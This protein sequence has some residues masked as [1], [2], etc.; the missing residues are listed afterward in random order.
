MFYNHL[1]N[2]LVYDQKTLAVHLYDDHVLL[3]LALL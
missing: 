3:P 2:I 1:K